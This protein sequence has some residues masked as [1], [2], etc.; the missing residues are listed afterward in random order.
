MTPKSLQLG[1][2]PSLHSL[3]ELPSISPKQAKT[4][5][6]LMKGQLDPAKVLP[7][8][9]YRQFHN[10]PAFHQQIMA[11]I[12]RTLGTCGVE[13]LKTKRGRYQYCNTGDSYGYT[14]VRCL[15]RRIWLLTTWGDLAE[16]EGTRD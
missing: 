3:L 14:V 8:S 4:I 9:Y 5:R 10:P 2:A 11:A 16:R 1:N 6:Q 12:D 13:F 7:D 15:T